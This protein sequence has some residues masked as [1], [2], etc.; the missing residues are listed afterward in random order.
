[1]DD[2]TRV[3]ELL[4]ELMILAAVMEMGNM[5]HEGGLSKRQAAIATRALL[6]IIEETPATMDAVKKTAENV[7]PT[8]CKFIREELAHDRKPQR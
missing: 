7:G 6:F 2:A 4:Q 5:M 3:D 1:M 8:V